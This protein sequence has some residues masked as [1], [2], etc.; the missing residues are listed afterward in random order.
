MSLLAKF[1]GCCEPRN[2]GGH[3]AYGAVMTAAG[4]TLWKASAYVG[5]G[6]RMSN[7]VAEYC[8]LAAVLTHLL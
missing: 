5:S 8:G 6:P 1:G 3:A 7:N 2:P 4:Q